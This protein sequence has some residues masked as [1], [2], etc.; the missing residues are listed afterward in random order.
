MARIKSFRP[1]KPHINHSQCISV[2]TIRTWAQPD[3]HPHTH[4]THTHTRWDG[5]GEIDIDDKDAKWKNKCARDSFVFTTAKRNWIY[6]FIR[7]LDTYHVRR[8]TSGVK[9]ITNHVREMA[10]YDVDTS[11][12]SGRV[13]CLMSIALKYFVSC[14]PKSWLTF[15]H[16]SGMARS[17]KER[18]R[19]RHVPR[20]GDNL[21][22]LVI[23]TK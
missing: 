9:S 22:R 3:R 19:N 18:R 16:S 21:I 17:A 15:V 1:S 5:L 6:L 12:F 23:E 14:L 7:H 13:E 4:I 11:P 2:R 8:R 10:C 20:G